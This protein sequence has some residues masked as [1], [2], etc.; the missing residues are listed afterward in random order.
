MH[1]GMSST[2][3]RRSFLRGGAASGALLLANPLSALAARGGAAAGE[4]Y[5]PL[6]DA[7]EIFLPEGFTCTVVSRAGDT[8]SDGRPVPTAFDGMGAFP[9]AGGETILVRNHENRRRAGETPVVVPAGLRYDA[10]P[11]YNAGCTKL[12]VDGE[13]RRVEEFAVLGGTTTNCAGGP[14]PWGSWLTCEEAFDAGASPHGFVFEIPADAGGPVAAEPIIGAGRFVHE[15]AAW[16]DGMLFLTEDRG[17]ACLYRYV[18]DTE[19]TG[20]G[21]L[22]ASTGRLEAL[23]IRGMDRADTRR[24]W[25]VGHEYDVE[26][27]LVDDPAPATESG[28]RSTRAQAQAKGAAIFSRQEGTWAVGD[29][30]TFD[31]TDGGVARAGQI[32]EL[33]PARNVLTLVYE[34]PSADVLDAPDNLCLM[35]RTGD[36]LL[37]E[38]GG[39]EQF[40]RGLTARAEIYD[41]ARSK[42]RDSEFCGA[43]FDA[44]GLVLFLNQQSPGVTYAITGPWKARRGR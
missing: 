33:D 19:I 37:C 28:G 29:R 30:V 35:P 44:K 9:G 23:K 18:P 41:F 32:W 21:E 3:D 16:V 4:G 38:D 8:M 7:G 24:S 14:T 17:D 22:A 5:G 13:L 39:G 10:D 43:C 25:P 31:C 40:V 20:P 34:S 36:V 12:V 6:V 15:A 42:T 27:V 2:I 1:A 11:A 26:W